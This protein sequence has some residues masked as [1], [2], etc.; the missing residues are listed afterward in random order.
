ME[1]NKS[2]MRV[3]TKMM[4]A[5]Q[6]QRIRVGKESSKIR[7]KL[8]IQRGGHVFKAFTGEYKEARS[9]K[10]TL[11]DR[12]PEGFEVFVNWLYQDK[13]PTWPSIKFPRTPEVLESSREFCI[14]RIPW[15]TTMA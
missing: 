5:N 2:R 8:L 6:S 4:T 7:K 13:L 10:M 14:I 12:D 15:Q 11:D 3:K 9:N 1:V